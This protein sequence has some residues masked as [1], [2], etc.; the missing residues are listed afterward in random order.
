[1]R[2]RPILGV[3]AAVLLLVLLLDWANGTFR[4][5]FGRYP[6]EGTHYITGL[7]IRDFVASGWSGWKDPT[8]FAF[9]YYAHLPKIALGNWPPVFEI[10]QA[11]WSLLFGV[12]RPTMLVEMAVFTALLGVVTLRG[13]ARYTTSFAAAAATAAMIAAPLTQA[14]TAMIMAEVPLA[15]FSLLAIFAWVRFLDDGSIRN[16]LIFGAWTVIAILTKGNGWVVPLVIAASIALLWKWPVLGKNSFWMGVSVVVFVCL[17]YTLFTMSIVMQGWN[18]GSALEGD[19]VLNSLRVH[20]GYIA[21]LLGWPLYLLAWAG[22]FDRVLIPALRR[23]RIAPFWS[24]LAVYGVAIWIFHAVVPTSFEPRKIYQIAPVIAAFLAAGIDLLGRGFA[25]VAP[26][27]IA[28]VAAVAV[29]AA[30]FFLS[31][32][33]L[34]EPFA[35]GFGPAVAVVIADPTSLG[36]AVLISSS[37]AY[38]DC[39]AG[40]IAEW[41]S[42][43]RNAGTYLTRGT[44]Q[45][46]YPAEIAG[47]PDFSPY[48]DSAA[49]L[50]ERIERIPISYAILHTTASDRT[51]RHHEMLQTALD[52]APQDWKLVYKTTVVTL[53]QPQTVE[54]YR[55]RKD[56]RGIPVHLEIDLSRKLGVTARAEPASLTRER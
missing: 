44:K 7:L 15:L 40:I 3:F 29:A 52:R 42:R 26:R 34:I 1:M 22:L 23:T 8:Q 27:Q 36:T 5:E 25:M 16:G 41:A 37:P 33:S 35:P 2:L 32:F 51:Y 53:G 54:A 48:D 19:T 24:I 18:Q 9:D 31:G 14:Q 39:E 45:L 11:A 46:A 20:H 6:D 55:Y 17:P 28:Q 50:A 30:G 12:S 49:A 43:Q 56:V 10:L 38:D 4:S 47:R 21:E 13:T